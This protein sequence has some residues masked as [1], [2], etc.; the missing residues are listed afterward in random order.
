MGT[1]RT[2]GT[3]KGEMYSGDTWLGCMLGYAGGC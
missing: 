1:N 2:R 3:E